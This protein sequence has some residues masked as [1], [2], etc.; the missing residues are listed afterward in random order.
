VVMYGGGV[1]LGVTDDMQKKGGGPKLG[2]GVTRGISLRVVRNARHA[3]SEH[4]SPC[5][6]YRYRKIKRS[7]LRKVELVDARYSP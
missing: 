6:R 2:L 1:C 3:E 7:A 5:R 4:V